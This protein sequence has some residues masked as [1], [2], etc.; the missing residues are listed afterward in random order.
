VIEIRRPDDGELCGFADERN[1]Q[2]MALTVFGAPLGEHDSHDAARDHVLAEGL[3]SLS[4]RWTLVNGITGETEIVCLLEANPSQV[5]VARDY[6]PLPGVP[7]LT[8]T[9][10]ELS[11]ADWELRR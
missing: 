1:A 3:A 4:D 8:I 6:F 2:W 7:T 11:S 10:A 5:T 9:A